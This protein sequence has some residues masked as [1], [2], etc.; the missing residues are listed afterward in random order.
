MKVAIVGAGPTGLVLS[1]ALARRGHRVDLIDRD[2]GPGTNG[3]WP[4]KGVMQF[5]HAHGVRKQVT[6]TL[7]RELPEAHER[8]L[9]AGAEPIHVD[10]PGGRMLIGTR[11]RRETLERAIRATVEQVPGVTFRIAHAAGV[12]TADGR[13]TGVRLDDGTVDADLVID[14]SGRSSRVTADLQAAQGCGAVCGMAYVDRQYQLNPGADP[15]P[16]LSPIAWQADLD[17]AQILVFPHERGMFSIVFARDTARPELAQLRHDHVFD[18]VAATI[19]GLAE[20]TDPARSHPITPVLAGG[21]L[22]NHYRSQRT[23]D[24]RL[25]LP[26]LISIG[27]AVCTTTPIFG[28]GL[29]TSMM[30]VDHLLSLLDGGADPIGDP[31]AIGTAFDDWCQ[32]HMRPWAEDHMTMDAAQIARW[33][34]EDV[35]LSRQLTSE[36]ILVAGSVDPEIP[37]ACMPY[38]AMDAGPEIVRAQESRARAVYE[39]GWRAP[40]SDGPGRAELASTIDTALSAA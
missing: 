18:A 1:A 19:P 13:A 7:L 15:G 3:S 14:A 22:R 8:W 35:D 16:L 2:G 17:G 11:S 38:F 12:T 10:T 37:K 25:R 6:D 39:T 23:P 27:D 36:Q 21:Q 32:A 20:W 24:G 40:L 9:A 28:R 4:R 31:E 34:G 5:H 26:G 30:Q 29:A 33:H